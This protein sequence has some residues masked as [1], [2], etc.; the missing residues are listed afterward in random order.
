LSTAVGEP[1]PRF[2]LINIVNRVVEMLPLI[3][4]DF[5]YACLLVILCVG[6]SLTHIME[7]FPNFAHAE[8]AGIGTMFI[9]TFTRLWG[10]NPYLGWPFASLLGGAIGV[11]LYALVVRPIRRAGSGG[12]VLTFAMFPVSQILVSFLTTYS[13]WVMMTHRFSTRGF[14]LRGHDFRWM[15][16]PGVLFVAPL[17]CVAL[18][19]SLHIFLTRV[20]LGIAIR[21]TAD[22]PELA[23]CLGIEVSRIH[24]V[25]WFLSGAMSALAGAFIPLYEK[26]TIGGS[27]ELLISVIAGSVLGGLNNIYGAVVGGFVVAIAQRTFPRL[28]TDLNVPLY[29]LKRVV[30]VVVIISVI[31]YEPG[32]ILG[33]ISRI[34]LYLGRTLRALPGSDSHEAGSLG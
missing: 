3:V 24:L 33:I 10:Y 6:F 4:D 5:I 1:S 28:L 30:P 21:A 11:L 14:I 31:M 13:I 2:D 29:G 19:A 22:D 7:K 18:V 17:I 16:Y 34:R 9:F 32:G 25:S 27:D 12:I 20:R 15:G 8:F 26:T 23:S